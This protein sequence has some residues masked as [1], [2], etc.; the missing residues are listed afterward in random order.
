MARLS[1]KPATLAINDPG[2]FVRIFLSYDHPRMIHGR[3]GKRRYVDKA[4]IEPGDRYND[5]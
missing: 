3:Q 4:R 1:F 2:L 5:P